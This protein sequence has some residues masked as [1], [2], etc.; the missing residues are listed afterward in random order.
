MQI[1]K[2][3]M[4]LFRMEY[5][6]HEVLLEVRSIADA[7]HHWIYIT[8]ISKI[9]AAFGLNLI[10]C[11]F[12]GVLFNKIFIWRPSPILKLFLDEEFWSILNFFVIFDYLTKKL[13]KN[14]IFA[15]PESC[16]IKL[17]NSIGFTDSFL[18]VK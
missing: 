13:S 15:K 11:W 10:N 17:V 1:A 4:F 7:L 9:K 3:F 5:V 14:Q 8:S 6:L 18:K 12:P 2:I 16:F